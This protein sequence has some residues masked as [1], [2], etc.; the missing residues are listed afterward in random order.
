[1]P[2][3]I[4]PIFEN[5]H[6]HVVPH[7][8]PVSDQTYACS[9]KTD[10]LTA[11]Y[12][13]IMDVLHASKFNITPALSIRPLTDMFNAIAAAA[14]TFDN[15][16]Q[17]FWLINATDERVSEANTTYSQGSYP[18]V[19]IVG[20]TLNADKQHILTEKSYTPDP[21][22]SAAAL[23]DGNGRISPLAGTLQNDFMGLKTYELLDGYK[24]TLEHFI[25]THP[26]S[27]DFQEFLN[28]AGDIGV[29]AVKNELLRILQPLIPQG[30]ARVIYDEKFYPTGQFTL[31]IQGG[32]QKHKWFEK[33]QA[34]IQPV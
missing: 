24:E 12:P 26:T 25:I 10:E 7:R 18:H 31:R 2:A 23:F 3:S 4:Q 9:L 6:F 28:K 20:G 16:K 22:A 11:Q 32:D 14:E 17:L 30:G 27:K 21:K 29:N 34:A 19:H 8:K 33:P 13:T 1:M 5:A 15:P